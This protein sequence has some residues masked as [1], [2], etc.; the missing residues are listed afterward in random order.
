MLSKL[1]S[2]KLLHHTMC[3]N[4]P[5]SAKSDFELIF[6]KSRVNIQC[7]EQGRLE[8]NIGQYCMNQFK[9]IIYYFVRF[10]KKVD[11]LL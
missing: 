1:I 7:D 2:H 10:P 11:I 3:H 6:C 5:Y 8:E 4:L 9:E